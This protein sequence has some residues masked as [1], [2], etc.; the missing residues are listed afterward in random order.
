VQVAE[1]AEVMA[2]AQVAQDL[3]ADMYQH[4]LL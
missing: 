2:T 1:L 4:N 3:V